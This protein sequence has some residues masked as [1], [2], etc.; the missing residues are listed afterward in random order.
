MSDEA[1][2]PT[3]LVTVGSTLFPH[4]TSTI[5]NSDILNLLSTRLSL[6]R[7]QIGKGDIPADLTDRI[8]PAPGSGSAR[9]GIKGEYKGMEV[10]VFRYTDDFEGLVNAVDLVV[11]HAGTFIAW[12]SRPILVEARVSRIRL[13]V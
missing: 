2:K 9:E 4:L 13:K 10:D 3:L 1:K 5:L 12:T 7:V 8:E 6:L 11:S